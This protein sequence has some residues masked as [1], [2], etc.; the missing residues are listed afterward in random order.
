MHLFY[1]VIFFVW[2]DYVRKIIHKENS[3]KKLIQKQVYQQHW[4]FYLL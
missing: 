3:A 2:Y 4:K 1:L